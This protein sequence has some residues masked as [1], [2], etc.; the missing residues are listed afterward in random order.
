MGPERACLRKITLLAAVIMAATCVTS[1]AAAD[2]RSVDVVRFATASGQPKPIDLVG[3][4]RRPDGDGLFPAVILPHGC[5]GEAA[6]LDRNWG[7]RIRSWGYVSLTV[8]SFGPRGITN[9]CHSGT[10]AGRAFDAYGAL[11]FLA[12]LA[13][14][15]PARVALMGFSEGGMMTLL[16]VEPRA[17]RQAITPRFRAA[18]AFYPACAGSGIVTA[19]TLILDGEL[20]DW[21]SAEACEKMVAQE[22]DIGITR[23]KGAS[24]P[25]SL[26]VLPGAYHK[27]DDPKFQ[28]G[29]RYMGH[30]LQYDAAAL[31]RAAEDV[32]AFLRTQLAAP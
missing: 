31:T 2:G 14:I 29:R 23:H 18:I 7:A 4:L 13:F 6:G 26:V 32:R 21:S 1:L 22:S 24:A 9:S 28:P 30:V 16:D 5:G 12:G 17:D 20:D 10:P 11:G 19:P 15:D 3:Y 8:D 25:M 27:F